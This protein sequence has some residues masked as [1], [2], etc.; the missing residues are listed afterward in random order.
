MRTTKRDVIGRIEVMNRYTK[1]RI[2]EE[3]GTDFNASYGGWNLWIKESG[4]CERGK[5]GFDCRKSTAE[6][7]SYISGVINSMAAITI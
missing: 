3:Y 4:G 2:G 7:M 6:F 1:S 5:L